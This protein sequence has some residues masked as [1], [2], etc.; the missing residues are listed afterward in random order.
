MN[1]L[2]KKKKMIDES[3]KHIEAQDLKILVLKILLLTT[4]EEVLAL[5]FEF[6]G[7]LLYCILGFV[8]S[9]HN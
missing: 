5:S 3:D 4:F 2:K 1:R 9:I 6:F 7:F 8:N